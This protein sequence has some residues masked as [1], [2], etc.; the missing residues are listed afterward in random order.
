MEAVPKEQEVRTGNWNSL[1]CHTPS[2]NSTSACRISGK[3]MSSFPSGAS[4]AAGDEV[5]PPGH[6]LGEK[7]PK[8][9]PNRHFLRRQMLLGVQLMSALLTLAY[10]NMLL[11]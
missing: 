4:L 7:E 2:A 6:Q 3:N 9:A 11:C 5:P 8:R 1:H 10:S